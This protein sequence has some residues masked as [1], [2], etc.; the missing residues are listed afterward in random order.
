MKIFNLKMLHHLHFL[1]Y[2]PIKNI[3]FP[4]SLKEK[5]V[6]PL[7]EDVWN[8]NIQKMKTHQWIS[9]HEG[10]RLQSVE[11][12]LFSKLHSTVCTAQF[13]FFIFK[14]QNLDEGSDD[15]RGAG[16]G[17]EIQTETY[18][19]AG[20][21]MCPCDETSR[22]S[23]SLHFCFFRWKWFQCTPAVAESYLKWEMFTICHLSFGSFFFNSSNQ[24]MVSFFSSCLIHLCKQA[25][26]ACRWVKLGSF[27]MCWPAHNQQ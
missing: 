9:L 2:F 15:S 16:G 6:M 5:A 4:H 10:A 11:L 19:M 17:R 12:S 8:I 13:F 23:Y 21:R 26:A 7:K 1:M 3:F 20:F 25:P 14:G 18:V 27:I 24:S 22:I